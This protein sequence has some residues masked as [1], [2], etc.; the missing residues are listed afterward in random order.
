MNGVLKHPWRVMMR[1]SWTTGVLALA[2][3]RY[4]VRCAFVPKADRLKARAVWQQGT[5]RRLLRV[6]RV[7]SEVHG[8]IPPTGLLVCNHLSYLDIIVLAAMTPA[9]F[10]AKREVKSWPVFGWLAGMAGTIF[11]QR[12]KRMRAGQVTDE[13]ETIMNRGM[14]VV[15]FPEGTSSGGETVLPF[16]SSLLEPATRQG[17]ALTAGLIG[18]ELE[19]GDVAEE[20]CYWK[21]MTFFPHLLNLLAKQGIKAS[22]RFT[23]MRENGADRKEL[24][25]KLHAELVRLKESV[26]V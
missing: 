26:P 9:V 2:A 22:V 24:A 4:A 15:L 5:A 14:L 21:D 1:F 17:R 7:S 25:R 6:L 19:D 23:E 8:T 16:K 3:A 10:V 12:E 20:V 11:V 13:I 18:Y